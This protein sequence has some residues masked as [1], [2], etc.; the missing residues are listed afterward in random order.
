MKFHCVKE[1]KEGKLTPKQCNEEEGVKSLQVIVNREE[2]RAE[3]KHV[4]YC[5]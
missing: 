3:K 2:D 5:K 4:I 1:W